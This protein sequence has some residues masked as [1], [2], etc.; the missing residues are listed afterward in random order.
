MNILFLADIISKDED[1]ED[2]KSGRY[3]VSGGGVPVCGNV[4]LRV[5]RQ[6]REGRPGSE[7][8]EGRTGEELVGGR[9]LSCIEGAHQKEQYRRC[10]ADQVSLLLPR[11]LLSGLVWNQAA[12]LF[13]KWREVFLVLTKDSVRWHTIDKTSKALQVSMFEM[14]VLGLHY[15]CFARWGQC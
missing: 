8:R 14:V 15:Y 13:A 7:V 6:V 11:P 5:K 2:M 1:L 12:G 3:S 9:P 4:K 10:R